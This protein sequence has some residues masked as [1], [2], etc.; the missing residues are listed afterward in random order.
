M[1]QVNGSESAFITNA[2]ASPQNMQ[3]YWSDIGCKAL[4][5][6]NAFYYI[7]E[8][9]GQD[10]ALPQWGIFDAEGKPFIDLGCSATWEPTGA[11]ALSQV[12]GTWNKPGPTGFR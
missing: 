12:N 3:Q 7:D 2:V 1:W 6:M 11:P 5:R 10:K 9:V 8:D 4:N